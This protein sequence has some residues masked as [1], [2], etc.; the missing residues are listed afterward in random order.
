MHVWCTGP[1]GTGAP[2]VV[3]SA[4]GGDFASDWTLVQRPL[5]DSA[6]VCSYDR[7]GSG[8]SEPAPGSRTFEQE[9]FELRRA[10]ERAGERAPYVIVGH[11]LGAFVARRFAERYRADVGGIVLVGPTNENGKLGYRGR[12]ILMRTVATDRV[13][14]AVDTSPPPSP[15]VLPGATVDSCRTQAAQA[16][17]ITRP[18]DQLRA[19]AQR[20]RLWALSHPACRMVGDD[21]FAEEMASFYAQ[22]STSAHPLGDIPLTVV[23]GTRVERPPGLSDSDWRS[24]SLRI[25]LSKLSSRGRLVLDSLSGHHVQLDRPSIVVSVVR[26]VM[27]QIA[28]SNSKPH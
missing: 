9:A 1:S 10:L 11:S 15:P 8:W 27:R 4:G 14:P 18:Y 19:Q 21:Y 5:S 2:T 20:Y 12:F 25:D 3:L 28:G 6:R 17:R 16:A 7:P 13:I 26:D 22:W 23:L 24:D